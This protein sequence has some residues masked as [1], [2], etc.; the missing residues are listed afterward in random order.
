MKYVPL[1]YL[2]STYPVK[3]IWDQQ[4]FVY[5]AVPMDLSEDPVNKAPLIIFM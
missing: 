1:M 5:L 3:I 4:A 2:Q